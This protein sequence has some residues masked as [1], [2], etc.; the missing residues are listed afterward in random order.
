M[1]D[2]TIVVATFNRRRVV[3]ATLRRLTALPEAVPIIVVDNGSCD[4]TARTIRARRPSVRVLP[5]AANIGAAART[6]GV[7]AATTRYVAFCDDDCWWQ[8]GSLAEG[9]RLLDAHPGVALINARVVVRGGCDDAC[10]LMAASMLPKRTACPGRA[11]AQFMAGAAI[12]RR[13]AFL[14]AGGFDRRYHIGAEESL[15]ALDLLES[16]WEMIYCDRLVV[17]HAPSPLARRPAERR[18][19]VMRNRLWTSWLRRSPSAVRRATLEMVLAALHDPNARAALAAALRGL[20][21]IVRERRPVRPQV[22]RL[23]ESLTELPA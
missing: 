22:E 12:V 21:W 5:L 1:T 19:L 20:P 7:R 9:V 3:D 17:H 2:C 10:A 23:M 13:D 14:A 8:P 18:R 6:E 4:G 16:G 15:L 11:I